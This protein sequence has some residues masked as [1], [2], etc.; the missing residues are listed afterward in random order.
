MKERDRRSAP[1]ELAMQFLGRRLISSFSVLDVLELTECDVLSIET[2]LGDPSL[3]LDPQRNTLDPSF[4]A[5][6][7]LRV[8]GVLCRIGFSQVLDAIIVPDTV[9]V[10]KKLLRGS[11]E[12]DGESYPM[13]R[14]SLPI[15]LNDAI[16]MLAHVASNSASSLSA[17]H[18]DFPDH[19]PGNG[20]VFDDL[21][22]PLDAGDFL[23]LPVHS[24]NLSYFDA[25]RANNAAAEARRKRKAGTGREET[26]ASSYDHREGVADEEPMMTIDEA[27]AIFLGSL[28]LVRDAAEGDR[29]VTRAAG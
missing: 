17:G 12:V 23:E 10:I 22:E 7:N 6:R 27:I 14:I 9:D 5:H 18:V 19:D 28:G 15:D 1:T 21:S 26:G 4:I 11:P 20:V 13:S 29:R 2:D 8:S 25:R 3:R 16:P 24:I